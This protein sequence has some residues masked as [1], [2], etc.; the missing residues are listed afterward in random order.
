MI[1]KKYFILT[2]GCQMNMSDS[3]RIAFLLEN[4]GYQ[5]ALN[6]TMADLIV[7]NMCSV[8]QSAVNRVYGLGEKIKKLKKKNRNLKTILTGC[9][10]KKDH[11]KFIKI[12]DLVLNIKSLSQWPKY[13]EAGFLSELW[14]PLLRQD[15]QYF[16]IQPKQISK[17]S[18]LIPISSGC[19]NSCAYCVV[20]FTRGP[21]TCR[22]HKEI[23]KETKSAIK[24]GAKEIWLLGQNVNDYKSPAN[25]KINFSKLLEMINNINADFWIRFTS[26]NPKDFS[27]EIIN[28]IANLKKVTE[29]LNLPVQSGD[30]K[31]LKEMNRSYTIKKYKDLVTKIRKKIPNISLST[32]AIVGFPTETKSQFQNTLKLFKDVK[33]D[34]AYIAKYSPRPRTKANKLKDDISKKEKQIRWEA[35]TKTL[36]KTSL[37]KN[38]KYIGK[39]VEIL[40]NDYK[41]GFIL[42]KTRTYKTVKIK[43]DDKDL[44]G[45]IIKVKI[46]S[47]LPWGLKGILAKPKLIVVLGSTATGKTGLAIKLAKQFNGEI[48]SADSRQ[49]Y[50]EMAIG[51]AKPTKKETKAIPHHLINFLLPNKDFNVALY[52]NKALKAI[53]KIQKTAKIPF[54]VGGTGLYISSI[55]NNID[56]PKVKPNKKLRKQLEK[57]SVRQLFEIYKKLDP[58]GAE[59][60]DRNNKRRLVR[61]IEVSEITKKPYWVQ[62]QKK[63]PLFEV[64][65]IGIKLSKKELEQRI[66]K[67]TD[68]MFKLGLEKEV[69]KLAKKYRKSPLLS[70]IGYTE[71][72]KNK[73][74]NKIKKAIKLHTIQFTNRQM[75]WFKKDKTINWIKNY[76]QAEKL[77]K[78]FL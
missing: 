69:K 30:N 50:K 34:M 2:Y 43:N 54:L 60:I 47:A 24:N 31:I 4:Q 5:Q 10:S 77:I 67:R 18:A 36:E 33:F 58:K 39:E 20:P 25:S 53:D 42:G 8:R 56:F 16:K 40:V 17:F 55:V 27:S 26:P 23:I 19:N 13:F 75:T 32:D 7:I 15:N 3:E 21:L 59:L 14:P 62:R 29:Y 73:D 41:N 12:F 44:I 72:F 51:T 11:K 68:K 66:S 63:E 28:A 22:S 76:S 46:T 48:V 49:I 61:A 37:K 78:R 45:K 65:Q 38:K 35:L 74:K 9:V 70:T 6:E 52:K 1:A 57:K 71:W 64:L